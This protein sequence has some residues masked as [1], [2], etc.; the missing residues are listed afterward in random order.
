MKALRSTLLTACY[1]V[2]AAAFVL[3]QVAV[4]RQTAIATFPSDGAIPEPS[5]YS[6][7]RRH[8][9]ESR[10][11]KIPKTLV[12]I[13][14]T[15]EDT[16]KTWHRQVFS[17]F[18]GRVCPL[19]DFQTKLSSKERRACQV[20]YTFVIGVNPSGPTEIVTSGNGAPKLLVKRSDQNFASDIQSEDCTLLN[21]K[22]V[23]TLATW[24]YST[25][26][27]CIETDVSSSTSA[28]VLH[29]TTFCILLLLTLPTPLHFLTNHVKQQR[30]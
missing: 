15:L 19:G 5:S 4:W 21:I 13:F 3:L 14:S 22:Y 30:K 18:P 8:L 23:W 29:V 7:S 12:A 24:Q 16:S 27:Y 20:I 28:V 11:S 6:N 17:Q 26:L 9:R 1:I 10:P 25:V 2:A